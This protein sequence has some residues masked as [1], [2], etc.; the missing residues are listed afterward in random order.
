MFIH[1]TLLIIN[2]IAFMLKTDRILLRIIDICRE[3]QDGR[4]VYHHSRIIEWLS[5]IMLHPENRSMVVE[6]IKWCESSDKE[7]YKQLLELK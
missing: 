2:T 7:Y 5:D 4:R 3:I 1:I 6:F